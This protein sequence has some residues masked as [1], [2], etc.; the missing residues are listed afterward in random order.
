MV[1]VNLLKRRI[2][3]FLHENKNKDADNLTSNL[4]NSTKKS[5]IFIGLKLKTPI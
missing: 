2:D 1:N 5:K 4:K 3:K